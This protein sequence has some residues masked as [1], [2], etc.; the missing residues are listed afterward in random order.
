MKAYCI[1]VLK[2]ERSSKAA[3]LRVDYIAQMRISL[4]R[5]SG[6]AIPLKAKACLC[7]MQKLPNP[8]PWLGEC[9]CPETASRRVLIRKSTEGLSNPVKRHQEG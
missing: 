3:R 7:R 1:S 9:R 8:V 4:K 5:K 6:G 2:R